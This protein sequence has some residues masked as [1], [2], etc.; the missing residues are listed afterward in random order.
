MN[1]GTISGNT[2][3]GVA[4]FFTV[5]SGG[6]VEEGTFR[7]SNGIIYGSNEPNTSLR[8]TATN[9]AALYNSGTAQRGTFS[10]DT[11]IRSGDLSTTNN[12]IRVVRGNI[13]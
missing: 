10:G 11:W 4:V 1:G 7:M 6:R 13:Q 8:N 9:G 12:T 3:G 2:G 5:Y